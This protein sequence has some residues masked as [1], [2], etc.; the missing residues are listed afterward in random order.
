MIYGYI[1]NFSRVD[2]TIDTIVIEDL[3]KA[4]SVNER[5]RFYVTITGGVVLPK[6]FIVTEDYQHVHQVMLT[7]ARLILTG[8]K[9]CGKSLILIKLISTRG[10]KMCYI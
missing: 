5:L 3:D 4:I 6:S 2:D 8:P 9:G 10:A 1:C 7:Q